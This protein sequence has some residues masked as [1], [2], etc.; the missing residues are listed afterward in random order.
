MIER[1]ERTAGSPRGTGTDLADGLGS[2][3]VVPSFD[4]TSHAQRLK[5]LRNQSL[6]LGLNVRQTRLA[7]LLAPTFTGNLNLSPICVAPKN[8]I[9]Q[10]RMPAATLPPIRPG[11]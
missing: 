3:P 10:E 4:K 6:A 7:S 2:S 11:Q 9:V 1:V 8:P 5:K